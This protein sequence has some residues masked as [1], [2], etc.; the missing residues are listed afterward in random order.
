[1][2]CYAYIALHDALAGYVAL[3]V[4]RSNHRGAQHSTPYISLEN[5]WDGC[6]VFACWMFAVRSVVRWFTTP[7][8]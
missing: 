8:L 2:S 3:S 1:M 5:E 4:L 6:K 7:M